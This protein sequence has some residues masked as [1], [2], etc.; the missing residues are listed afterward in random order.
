VPGPIAATVTPA[1]ARASP[2]SRSSSGLGPFAE[3]T[4]TRS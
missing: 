4:Q 3:V 2:P 1:S